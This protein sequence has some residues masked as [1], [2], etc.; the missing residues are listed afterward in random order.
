MCDIV[1]RRWSCTTNRAALL[2]IFYRVSILFWVCGFQ[3][4]SPY[5]NF[6]LTSML[7]AASFTFCLAGYRVHLSRPSVLADLDA[8]LLICLIQ[9][10][11]ASVVTPRYVRELTREIGW[12]AMV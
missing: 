1:V 7:Q 12:F 2:S 10:S 9:D 3:A 8:V 5:S 6:G 4:I 11:L